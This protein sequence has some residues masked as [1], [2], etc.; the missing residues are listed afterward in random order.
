MKYHILVITI[1]KLKKK[2]MSK[3]FKNVL[4]VFLKYFLY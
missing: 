1:A 4:N 3:P 2:K